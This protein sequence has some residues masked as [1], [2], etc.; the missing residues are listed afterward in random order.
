M[1]HGLPHIEHVHQLCADC[2]TTKLKRSLFP[3]QAKRREE[4]LLDLVH[5][6]LCGPITLA[7][8]G[9][10]QYFLLLVDDKS[11][12][13]W[14]VLL[15]V[16]SDTLAAIKKFQAK[17]EVE[18]GRRLRVLRTDNRGEFTSVAFEEYC[19]EHGIERQKTAPYTPQQNGVVEQRNQTVVTMAR[20][21]L[22]S[23]NMPAMF[24][25]EA[26]ATTVFLLNRA[27]TKAVDGMTPYEA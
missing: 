17:V 24:W 9:D 1:V 8:P 19:I 15:A 6:D 12:Y 18:T 2:I 21:L 22:K 4:G 14:A 16:K 10:K 20:S 27:P 13:M 11:R 23:R 26:V 7:T 3:L 5:G 25:G